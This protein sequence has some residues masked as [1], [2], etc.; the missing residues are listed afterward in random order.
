MMP[1]RVLR[2]IRSDLTE[3]RFGV[4][5]QMVAALARRG[6]RVAEVP[7]NYDPRNPAAGKKIGWRDGVRA[8]HVIAR[9]WMT[10]MG[11]RTD[12]RGTGTL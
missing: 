10:T 1:A 7:V 4:E 11:R 8:L 12:R 5:P 3:T 6:Y 9:E 2:A